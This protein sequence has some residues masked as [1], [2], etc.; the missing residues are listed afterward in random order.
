M[1]K[2]AGSYFLI[3]HKVS[4]KCV[5]QL[6]MMDWLPKGNKSNSFLM[7]ALDKEAI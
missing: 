2:K 3:S 1:G 7:Q 5:S 6:F 4:G